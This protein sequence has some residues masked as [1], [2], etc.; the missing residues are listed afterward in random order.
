MALS[1]KQLAIEKFEDYLNQNKEI[2]T[3]LESVVE[4]LEFMA[5]S[6]LDPANQSA[7]LLRAFLVSETPDHPKPGQPE[8][9]H[10]A[11]RAALEE[12]PTRNYDP[13]SIAHGFDRGV[14]WAQATGE[15]STECV[16]TCKVLAAY[17]EK[18]KEGTK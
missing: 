18:R 11:V 15:C 7:K 3:E 10:E 9:R 14:E 16:Y 1:E 4:T 17:E 13:S 6:R 8:A 2:R 5:T 12:H